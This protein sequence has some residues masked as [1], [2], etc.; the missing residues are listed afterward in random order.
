M[1]TRWFDANQNFIQRRDT[2]GRLTIM[3]YDPS[4][5]LISEKNALG[6]FKFFNYDP[7]GNATQFQD[8][9]SKT[10][11]MAYDANNR[12]LAVT[13]PLARQMS[14]VRD[15]LGRVITGVNGRGGKVD[16]TYDAD[17]KIVS[18]WH[19]AIQVGT[20]TYN[21]AGR[22]AS[23]AD[24]TGT[25][26]Y[27]YD[28]AGRVIK[29]TY[30][31]GLVVQFTYDAAGNLSTITYPGGLAAVYTYDSR[32]R[33]QKAAWGA[34]SIDFTYDALGQV[35]GEVRSNG[36]E[37]AYAYD[38]NNR[39]STL[40][41]QK[42]TAI[43]ADLTYGRDAAGNVTSITGDQPL[44]PT[45]SA[46]DIT[47][48]YDAANQIIARGGENYTYDADGNLTGAG[49]GFQAE[50][51]VENRPVALS[52][53]GWTSAMAYDGQG[54]R[55]EVTAAGLTRQCYYD[56]VGRLL[57]ETDEAGVLTPRYFYAGMRLAAMQTLPGGVF[58]FYH[59]DHL[60]STLALTSG[61]GVIQ[62]KYAYLPFGQVAAHTG[63][64]PNPFTFVGAAG[65]VDDGS[66][67]FFMK[68]R[69]YDSNSGRFL[70]KDPIGFPGGYNLY[71][72]AEDNPLRFIDPDGLAE[73]PPRIYGAEGEEDFEYWKARIQ[74]Y[75]P[76]NKLRP[77]LRSHLWE[78]GWGPNVFIVYTPIVKTLKYVVFIRKYD[79]GNGNFRIEYQFVQFVGKESQEKCD[80]GSGFLD[81]LKT[82]FPPGTNY[83]VQSAYVVIG[84]A[85]HPRLTGG[86]GGGSLPLM[87]GDVGGYITERVD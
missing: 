74:K 6:K 48:T 11:L 9:R 67:L 15:A 46:A 36:T 59:F 22:L 81:K 42:G 77:V 33:L 37:S 8:E 49:G 5:R 38:A 85:D 41:H 73:L 84:V 10:T 58:Y 55:R 14:Y 60:G 61:T 12:L 7:N 78:P 24:A 21:T 57:F 44:W 16:L 52:G 56:H 20:Y 53:P 50:Y 3:S 1:T 80:R 71:R 86:G 76:N 87:P 30:P 64:V 27:T 75:G 25:M 18:K 54:F 65:V 68:N 51:D 63:T 31:H 72:Y 45:L 70:H 66:G 83:R 35:T 23:C 79:M 39:L 43:F 82:F 47:A 19:D 28:A 26:V 32:N 17:G 4:D 29:I 13:D 69:Y 40:R 62:A 2:L 34:R